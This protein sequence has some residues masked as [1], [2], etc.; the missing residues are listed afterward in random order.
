MT[1]INSV[2]VAG[3][4]YMPSFVK[5]GVSMDTVERIMQ[6]RIGH[7]G[8]KMLGVWRVGDDAPAMERHL[9]LALRAFRVEGEWFAV[10]IEEL[11][12]LLEN[13]AS[14]GGSPLSEFLDQ[15]R[16]CER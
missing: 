4:R 16:T 6:L 7:P 3:S 15:L 9:H 12:E 14:L 2:Y 11:I 10:S 8:L 5:I 1:R 13:F